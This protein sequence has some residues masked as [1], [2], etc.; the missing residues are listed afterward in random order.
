MVRSTLE[1]GF[2][3]VLY[4]TGSLVSGNGDLGAKGTP[5]G[6]RSS[7]KLAKQSLLIKQHLQNKLARSTTY[8]GV[9]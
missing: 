1:A 9:K 8:V 6:I 3:C 7:V 5:A 4:D 2:H